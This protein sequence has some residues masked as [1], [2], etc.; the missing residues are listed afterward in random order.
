MS[1]KTSAAFTLV[2]MLVV[3]SIIAVIAGLAFPAISGAITRSQMV[4]AISNARQVYLATSSMAT[5]GSSTG[6]PKYGW[7]GDLANSTSTD[8]NVK[9]TTVSDFVTRLVDHDY[10][11]SGDLKVFAAPGVTPWTGTYTAPADANS[12]GS[13]SPAYSG[14]ANCAFKVYK[15]SDKDA[16]NTIF[17]ATKNFTYSST[18]TTAIDSTKKPF[19]DSGFVVFHKG[20]DGAS[21]KKQQAT[22]KNLLGTVPASTQSSSTTTQQNADESAD[23][24]LTQQ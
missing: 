17:M 10:L 1:R 14:D 2:E 5:D 3:I 22:S 13:F 15:V 24:I 23:S 7:P 11:K 6:D 18:Q 16:S 8:P 19:G 4:Q 9:I 20:G 21:Y 12:K